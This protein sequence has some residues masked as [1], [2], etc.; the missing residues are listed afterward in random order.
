MTPEEFKHR[1]LL[2]GLSQ[3]QLAQIL[4]VQSMTISSWERRR[5]AMPPYIA[6]LLRQVETD[7]AKT[8]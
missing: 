4:G 1:R 8:K 7:I 2:M 3:T 6:L 5:R